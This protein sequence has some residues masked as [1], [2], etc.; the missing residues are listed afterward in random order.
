MI[1]VRET[2]S[3]NSTSNVTSDSIY[4]EYKEDIHETWGSKLVEEFNKQ[5]RMYL[6]YNIK[7]LVCP[8]FRIDDTQKRWGRWIPLDRTIS[9]SLRLL[10]DYSW[11]AVVQTLK[12]EMAHMI[13]DEIYAKQGL[14]DSDKSHGELF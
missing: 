1:D 2:T 12:H 4:E 5:N 9:I 7:Q 10:R 8:T 14:N 3:S 11:D 13:V 6:S